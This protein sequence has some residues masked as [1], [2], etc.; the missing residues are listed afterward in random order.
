MVKGTQPKCSHVAWMTITKKG[1]Q[2]GEIADFTQSFRA[3]DMLTDSEMHQSVHVQAP[4]VDAGVL[5]RT[6][7]VNVRFNLKKQNKNRLM[8]T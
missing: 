5:P 2:H 3:I 4:L 1:F 7:R 6:D 8:R